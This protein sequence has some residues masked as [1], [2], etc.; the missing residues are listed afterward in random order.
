MKH[1]Q[2]Q[3][4]KNTHVLFHEDNQWFD[5]FQWT[6]LVPSSRRQ[7]TPRSA[8]EEQPAKSM[9]PRDVF[10]F[11]LFAFPI[12]SFFC[13]YFIGLCFSL[14]F[15]CRC[16]ACDLHLFFSQPKWSPREE[17]DGHCSSD[18]SPPQEQERLGFCLLAF[19]IRI[20]IE[21]ASLPRCF[22]FESLNKKWLRLYSWNLADMSGM[23]M[24]RNRSN[25]G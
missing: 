11:S 18:W 3:K 15:L 16:S 21:I 17:T 14:P 2:K 5:M 1:Q 6:A 22:G 19:S 13:R 25:A 20:L 9:W 10:L 4:H 8:A 12:C 23:W 7:G 24:G